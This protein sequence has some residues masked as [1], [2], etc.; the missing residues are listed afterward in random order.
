MR[1]T[2]VKGS[3]DDRIEIRRADGS[4]ADTRFPKKGPVPHDAVHWIVEETLGLPDGFW[5]K[6]AGGLH[7]DEV[8]EMAK[9]AGHASAARASLPDAT[10]I[11]LL[12]A[13]RLVE[14]FEAALWSGGS[15]AASVRHMGEAGCATSHVDFPAITDAQIDAA[16]ARVLA[17]QAEWSPAPAG[18]SMSFEWPAQ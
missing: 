1:V 11:Q 9:A 15:D 2:I 17:M 12:Q 13:E 3:V 4:T 14:C 16:M 8:Q 5:G 18:H 6:I 7:P 10:I